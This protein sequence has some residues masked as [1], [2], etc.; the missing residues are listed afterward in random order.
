MCFSTFICVGCARDLPI[1]RRADCGS[2]YFKGI[3]MPFSVCPLPELA[4]FRAQ[5]QVLERSAARRRHMYHW[6]GSCP[7]C[8]RPLRPNRSRQYKTACRRRWVV[9][10]SWWEETCL[11]GAR[12][13][14][15]SSGS[16]WMF[17]SPSRPAFRP[18]WLV[19][20]GGEGRTRAAAI[21]KP[22][23]ACCRLNCRKPGKSQRRITGCDA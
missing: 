9:G 22:A 15:T 7:P 21:V 5:P 6:R 4:A 2:L 10:P 23:S 12:T 18:P 20:L 19:G 16:R 11:P 1:R 3:P 13:C 14:K 8:S 17:T